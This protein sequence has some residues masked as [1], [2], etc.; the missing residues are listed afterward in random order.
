MAESVRDAAAQA[1]HDRLATMQ[2]GEPAAD[3]YPWTWSLT[4]RE[5]LSD[6]MLRG[7][8]YV[9]SVLDTDEAVNE[10]SYPVSDCVLRCNVEFHIMVQSGE[11]P[12]VMLNRALAAVRRKVREDR[13][14]GGAVR[15]FLDRGSTLDPEGAYAN[16]V[17][18]VLF[19]DLYYRH[20]Q[21]DPRIKI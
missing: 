7:K 18:G 11:D 4:Q 13:T 10:Q 20:H 21:S 16:Y 19:L 2:G 17:S 14:L 12:A 8:R 3:P 6:D 9:L 5:P 15:D 1:L